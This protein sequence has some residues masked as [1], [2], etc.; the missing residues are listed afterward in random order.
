MRCGLLRQKQ[1]Q[2]IL[3]LVTLDKQKNALY[4][5]LAHSP[6]GM[7]TPSPNSVMP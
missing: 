1:S 4:D 5:K 2:A 3:L 6:L 7:I